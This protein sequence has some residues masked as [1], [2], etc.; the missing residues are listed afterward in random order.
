MALAGDYR[1]R[2]Y[3]EPPDATVLAPEEFGALV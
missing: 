3:R 2:A 1:T